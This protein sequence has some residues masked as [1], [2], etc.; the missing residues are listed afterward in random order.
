MMM[1]MTVRLKHIRILMTVMCLLE[2]KELALTLRLSESF[3]WADYHSS[4][5]C[6]HMDQR[7]LLP[8]FLLIIPSPPPVC[9]SLKG[10]FHSVSVTASSLSCWKHR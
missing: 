6:S 4:L 7:S 3:L 10:A 8:I 5:L 1:M 9:T 2:T